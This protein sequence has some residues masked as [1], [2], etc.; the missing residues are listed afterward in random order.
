MTDPDLTRAS[1]YDFALPGE[2][3]AVAPPPERR[4]ARLLAVEPGRSLQDLVIP[5][6]VGLLEPGDVLVVN[7]VRVSPARLFA[8]RETGGLVELLVVGTSAEGIWDPSDRECLALFRSNRRV[9]VG[10]PLAVDGVGASVTLVSHAAE[11]DGPAR[12]ALDAPVLEV[13]ERAGRLPLPPYIERQRSERC[14]DERFD[15]LDAE[16]YQTV[17][18]RTPGAVAAPTAGLHFDAALLRELEAKGVVVAPVTL[19]VGIGTF[20]PVKAESL[21]EHVMHAERYRVPDETAAAIAACR[22]S[23]GRVVAVGTTVVR[24]L[25][26]AAIGDGR[27]RAGDGE[28]ALFVRPGYH[29]RVV[30]ALV[31]NFHLPRSTL[32]A[33]VCAL[34]GYG[35]VMGAY[36]H[37]VAAGYRFFSYGDAM[38]VVNAGERSDA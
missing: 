28:T 25:E 37:A 35:P 18:A 12:F 14:P 21:D 4:A 22:A 23:G 20:R 26:A 27:V 11:S 10:E 9:R 16:R 1:A 31:T 5:D 24:T 33:L 2:Q 36:R 34:G 3:I 6:L 8:R 17:W 30:D 13:L 15:E 19:V 32:L 38:F 7:D 29:F